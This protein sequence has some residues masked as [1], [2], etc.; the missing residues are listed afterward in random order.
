MTQ[1]HNNMSSDS[2]DLERFADLGSEPFWMQDIRL[3][4][5][6]IEVE[7]GGGGHCRPGGGTDDRS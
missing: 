3:A 5:R 2:D 4:R 1:N 6:K 7:R